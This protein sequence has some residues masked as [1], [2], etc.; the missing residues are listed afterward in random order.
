MYEIYP[1]NKKVEKLL[2]KLI[3]TRKDIV[4]KLKRLKK[5]PRKAL[6]AHSLHG[7]LEGKW[8]CWLGSNLRIVYIIDDANKRIEIEAAGTHKIY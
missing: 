4:E 5:N 8:S 6:D 7:Q 3:K 1:A 2:N